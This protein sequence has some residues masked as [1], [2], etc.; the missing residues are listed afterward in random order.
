MVSSNDLLILLK[1]TILSGGKGD[2]RSIPILPAIHLTAVPWASLSES[3][4][5]SLDKSFGIFGKRNPSHPDPPFADQRCVIKAAFRLP[6]ADRGRKPH[7]IPDSY[8]HKTR[9]SAISLKK[10]RLLRSRCNDNSKI[11]ILRESEVGRR[12]RIIL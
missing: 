7:G 8:Y 4:D 9:S 11:R 3:D 6:L 2:E 5:L 10:A 12:G 1:E